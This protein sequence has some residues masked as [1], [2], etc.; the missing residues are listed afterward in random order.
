[1]GLVKELISGKD[2]VVRG[3]KLRIGG[4][5][6]PEFLNRPLQKFYP[7][8]VRC[9]DLGSRRQETD[10]EKREEDGGEY[11][12]PSRA[13]RAAAKDAEWKTRFMLDSE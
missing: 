5:G 8:E 1:M 11:L 4:K 3:A 2:G 12:P 10:R 9:A 13:R 7:F 6:K